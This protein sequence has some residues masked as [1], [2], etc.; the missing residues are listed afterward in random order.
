MVLRLFAG[1]FSFGVLLIERHELVDSGTANLG[2]LAIVK[3]SHRILAGAATDQRRRVR[4]SHGGL[5]I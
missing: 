4:F 1:V 3:E 5:A 2:R